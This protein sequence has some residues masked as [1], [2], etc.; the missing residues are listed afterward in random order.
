MHQIKSLISIPI[1]YTNND[2]NTRF[3][4]RVCCIYVCWLIYEMRWLHEKNSFNSIKPHEDIPWFVAVRCSCSCAVCCS[5]LHCVSILNHDFC[6]NWLLK[7]IFLCM[8][9]NRLNEEISLFNL[10]LMQDKRSLFMLIHPFNQERNLCIFM[11]ILRL[12]T[13]SHTCKHLCE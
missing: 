10:F 9:N 5:V 7:S 2:V 12:N 3:L 8:L 6:N 4:A 11:W 13:C 1:R